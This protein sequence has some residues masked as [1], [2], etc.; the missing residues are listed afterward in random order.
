MATDASPKAKEAKEARQ[1]MYRNRRSSPPM[2]LLNPASKKVCRVCGEPVHSIESKLCLK[3]LSVMDGGRPPMDKNHS[4]ASRESF[5]SR[6]SKSSKRTSRASKAAGQEESPPASP[7]G[8]QSP[9]PSWSMWNF[10]RRHSADA[11][12][13]RTG[14]KVS[15][16]PSEEGMTKRHST[17]LKRLASGEAAKPKL[18]HLRPGTPSSPGASSKEALHRNRSPCR[19]IEA[20]ACKVCGAASVQDGKSDF[21]QECLGVPPKPRSLGPAQEDDACNNPEIELQPQEEYQDVHRQA[22]QLERKVQDLGEQL[23][24]HLA[25]RRAGQQQEDLGEQLA[26]HLASRR[27]QQRE[28]RPT[29]QPNVQSTASSLSSSLSPTGAHK[30]QPRR[31]HS[32]LGLTTQGLEAE[33]LIRP[34][35]QRIL[36]PMLSADDSASHSSGL[37]TLSAMLADELQTLRRSLHADWKK[38]RQ[39]LFGEWNKLAT[40][41]DDALKKFNARPAPLNL[42]PFAQLSAVPREFNPAGSQTELDGVRVPTME[43]VDTA[44]LQQ[45]QFARNNSGGD[46]DGE[47]EPY[48]PT[49]RAGCQLSGPQPNHGSILAH[50][51]KCLARCSSKGGLMSPRDTISCPTSRQ[52]SKSYGAAE[53]LLPG[54]HAEGG[55]PLKAVNERLEG[56]SELVRNLS[57]EM[58]SS[59]NGHSSGERHW[60]NGHYNTPTSLP[61]ARVLSERV[62][63]DYGA[64]S[65]EDSPASPGRRQMMA[66]ASGMGQQRHSAAAARQVP[67]G[68]GTGSQSF[69]P[70]MSLSQR[71]QTTATTW[72]F[73]GTSRQASDGGVGAEPLS[74][75]SP[76]GT[77][78]QRAAAVTLGPNGMGVGNMMSRTFSRT[79]QRTRTMD[80]ESKYMENV[81]AGVGA[82]AGGDRARKRLFSDG[83]MAMSQYLQ[84]DSYAEEAPHLDPSGRSMSGTLEAASPLHLLR[85]PPTLT[86]FASVDKLE[87]Y[88]E[89]SH[90]AGYG[91]DDDDDRLVLNAVVNPTP[92]PPAKAT[93]MDMSTIQKR[94][95]D[96]R[97]R[98]PSGLSDYSVHSAADRRRKSC[99]TEATSSVSGAAPHLILADLSAV[100]T[101]GEDS[102]RG[103]ECPPSSP[104]SPKR[105]VCSPRHHQKAASRALSPQRHGGRMPDDGLPLVPG[106]ANA[107][108]SLKA[109]SGMGVCKVPS[110]RS[111]LNREHSGAGYLSTC[112]SSNKSEGDR[113]KINSDG[114]SNASSSCDGDTE[115][116]EAR[117]AEMQNRGR[118]RSVLE[119]SACVKAELAILHDFSEVIPVK[120]R[121]SAGSFFSE[122]KS[123]ADLF[124]TRGSYGSSQMGRPS[125]L[126][127]STTCSNIDALRTLREQELLQQ[128][129]EELADNVSELAEQD[130]SS[131]LARLAAWIPT[132]VLTLFG[133]I[134]CPRCAAGFDVYG[135]LAML[136]ALG[137]VVYNAML[138]VEDFSYIRLADVV[139]TVGLFFALLTLRLRAINRLLGPSQTLELYASLHGY[140]E[141][142]M[143][144]SLQCFCFVVA[145]CICTV[146]SP[147][148]LNR[149]FETKDIAN[150]TDIPVGIEM[151]PLSVYSCTI[152]LYGAI[153]FSILHI[154]CGLEHMVDSFCI[155]F[156][157]DPDWSRGITE[158]NT[159]QAIIR[160]SGR[161]VDLCFL[162]L[163]TSVVAGIFLT[164]AG[165]LVTSS[166]DARSLTLRFA[167]WLPPTLLALFSLFRAASVTEKC[168][169]SPALVNSLIEDSDDTINTERQYMVHFMEHSAAGF[170]IQG[171]RLTSA[172]GLK[173]TYVLTIVCFSLFAQI[174]RKAD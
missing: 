122:M 136:F 25:S 133:I 108:L 21:C 88:D 146:G 151:P 63:E 5:K 95:R 23:A 97:S 59:S 27:A 6:D 135:M 117:L 171:V 2:G 139:F 30:Q 165:L 167:S 166:D 51:Q 24:E 57:R 1:R 138:V 98:A 131:T 172:M 8:C 39:E 173:Y 170:Y 31:R 33:G 28:E 41:V 74:P 83:A 36:L 47:S 37:K 156:F 7:S 3:C 150:S 4:L 121:T 154:S 22:Q 105:G 46:T 119:N 67:G 159:M 152:A 92:S 19:R 162:A 91:D 60:S 101:S 96:H 75:V 99:D 118:R 120:H 44:G 125:M 86:K 54:G 66:T 81:F 163:Q 72:S 42:S 84:Q 35:M 103:G 147:L 9:T 53:V 71:I 90:E 128:Q 20:K 82:A 161:T 40:T 89:A 78:K 144:N 29:R 115:E 127:K 77:R 140:H 109:D 169:R 142:W 34:E 76:G 158:W 134:P 153:V 145:S 124:M 62:T 174:Q 85:Q 94:L 48:S 141:T 56:L 11:T 107:L 26:E 12:S 50:Q 61:R 102:D 111:T 155:R 93:S 130:Y 18:S 149:F 113:S 110:D 17:S 15:E 104:T 13:S 16:A 64:R 70:T 132:T 65:A 58:T 32:D 137:I 49:E 69:G 80:I 38:T 73:S 164:G 126:R 68:S 112:K 123:A 43:S 100:A 114:D 79:N 168:L 52:A 116:D 148:L 143:Y 129:E 10:R 157:D 45:F 106:S 87:A 14:G 55:D 160:S